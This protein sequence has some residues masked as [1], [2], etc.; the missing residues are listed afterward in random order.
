[1]LH[2]FKKFL[3]KK[4]IIHL[5]NLLFIAHT[6][7]MSPEVPPLWIRFWDLVCH[8]LHSA[9]WKCVIAIFD[10]CPSDRWLLLTFMTETAGIK[11]SEHPTA[12][13]QGYPCPSLPHYNTSSFTSHLHWSLQ[14]LSRSCC[15]AEHVDYPISMYTLSAQ[16]SLMIIYIFKIWLK[17]S[18]ELKYYCEE[19][20]DRLTR[21]RK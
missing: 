4:S 18:G 3:W 13:W 10:D 16:I 5:P 8:V 14:R 2:H 15:G 12:A 17:L 6:Q 21:Q 20:T 9:L 11:C 1:M 19:P 7:P